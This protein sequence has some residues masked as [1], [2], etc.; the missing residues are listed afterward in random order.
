[1][2]YRIACLLLAIASLSTACASD[3][4]ALSRRE[5]W[6]GRVADNRHDFA[7]RLLK[8]HNEERERM[9]MAPLQWDAGLASHA[10]AWSADLARRNA[11]EHSP[12]SRR[13]GEGE[14]LFTGTAGAYSLEAM[15]G[16]FIAEKKDFRPGTFPAVSRTGQWSDVGHYT[17]IIWRST[18]RVGCGLVSRGGQDWLTCRYSPPGNVVGVKVP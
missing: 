3:G 7:A 12:A 11:F 13:P 17:Q 9:G 10:E 14:N 1:M 6:D 5:T 8:A 16:A 18:T 15:I 2:Q 4:G